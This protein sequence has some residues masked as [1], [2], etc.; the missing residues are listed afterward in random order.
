KP[1]DIATEIFLL[2]AAATAEMDGKY[3]NTQRLIQGNDRDAEPPG[4]ASSHRWFTVHLWLRLK[5]LYASSAL[6]RDRSIRA[7]TWDYIVPAENAEWRIKDEPSAAL[8]LKEMNGY[9]AATGRPVKGFGDLKAD[10][11]TACGAWI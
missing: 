10:G 3:T 1:E 2:P 8:V 5:R 7:L 11:T 9:H 6:E 4:D